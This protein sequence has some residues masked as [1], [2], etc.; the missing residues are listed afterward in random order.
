LSPQ[1]DH[2]DDFSGKMMIG[3]F[4]V[5]SMYLFSLDFSSCLVPYPL[6]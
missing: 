6:L 5:G 1:I 3:N 2:G 4:P